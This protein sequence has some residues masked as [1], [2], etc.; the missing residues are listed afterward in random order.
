MSNNS[1]TIQG[2]SLDNGNAA[3]DATAKEFLAHRVFLARILRHCVAEFRDCPVEDIASKYI[4]GKPEVGTVPVAPDLTNAP[5]KIIG[6][7]VEYKTLTEGMTVFDIRFVAYAPSTGEPIKLI[8]NIE[9]QKK[10]HP[11]YSLV[12]RGIFHGSRL[13]SS[14]YGVEF[15]EPD[16]DSIKK[17]VTIWLCM[18]SPARKESGI[19]EYR[20]GERQLA[21]QI[22]NAVQEYDLMQVVMVYIG[23]SGEAIENELLKL[24]HLVFRARLKAEEKTRRLRDEFDIEL[25]SNMRKELNIMC[26]LSE[27]IAE[28]AWAAAWAEATKLS[29]G[30]AEEARAAA[31]AEATKLSEGI[32]EEARAEAWAE[33]TKLSEGIAEETRKEMTAEMAARMLKEKIS[34][35]TVSRITGLSMEEIMELGKLHRLS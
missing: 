2:L 16:F 25:D 21:G 3:Y 32:A 19:T 13:M 1:D 11:G 28:E 15:E 20:F 23:S 22:S 18:T 27:G 8:V 29:E 4:E 30:I 12:R 24:L 14:Q 6:D 10:H 5:R 34:A 33:A 7:N 31:W 17:V 35:D 26:N 9:A